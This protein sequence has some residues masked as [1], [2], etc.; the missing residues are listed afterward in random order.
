MGGGS[1]SMRA[2]SGPSVS[3]GGP[4]IGA[5]RISSM[6]LRS[7]PSTGRIVDRDMGRTRMVEMHDHDRGHDR[8]HDRDFR[9]DH[10]RD[11]DHDRF[12]FRFFPTFAY[13]Y[14]TYSDVYDPG[15]TDCWELHRVLIH[16]H[17]RLR[18]IWVCDYN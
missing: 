15:Y 18:R 2:G 11:R 7:D 9:R 1:P 6:S 3:T 13:G 10:D 8:D 16:G 5:G 4:G 17:L 12:R 14:D